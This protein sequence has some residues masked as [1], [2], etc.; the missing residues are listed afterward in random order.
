CRL[1]RL[2]VSPLLPY[3]TLFRSWAAAPPRRPAAGTEARAA[4]R[5]KAGRGE[6]EV[7]SFPSRDGND[8]VGMR[9]IAE[10]CLQLRKAPGESP[11]HRRVRGIVRNVVD[12]R[13]VRLQVVQLPFGNEPPT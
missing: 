4:R 7:M 3:T 13:G 11:A 10:L 5:E 1:G 6:R 9:R 2:P 8:L 12:L